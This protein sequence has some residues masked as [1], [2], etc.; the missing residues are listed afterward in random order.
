MDHHFDVDHLSSVRL[1]TDGY[2]VKVAY[3]DFWPYGEEATPAGSWP[4]RCRRGVVHR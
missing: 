3:R 4:M 2:G 1:E